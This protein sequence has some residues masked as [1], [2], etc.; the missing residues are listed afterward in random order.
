MELG[1]WFSSVMA[2]VLSGLASDASAAPYLLTSSRYTQDFEGLSWS[3]ST[4]AYSNFG[5]AS[6]N[7]LGWAATNQSVNVIASYRSR[8]AS[9]LKAEATLV[10]SDTIPPSDLAVG[11]F[12]GTYSP[13]ITLFLMNGTENTIN[14]A[15][16]SFTV[17]LW[18]QPTTN[19]TGAIRAAYDV[20]NLW[21]T[22]SAPHAN[23]Y[24]GDG[25]FFSHAFPTSAA[26]GSQY[27]HTSVLQD[28]GWAP[29]ESLA[30][31]WRFSQEGFNANH[32][33]GIDD[34]LITVP[35]PAVVGPAAIVAF[36]TL[37]RRQRRSMSAT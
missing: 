22:E 35:E 2:V 24:F 7:T 16:I 28:L 25:T 15:Q 32:I 1:K 37:A 33:A 30:I 34:V 4:T 23:T 17:E 36:G 9:M 6:S 3:S 5:Q 10:G 18:S 20:G 11:R 14:E 12:S 19:L 8:N 21:T 13:W 27:L 29:G 26:A 31:M